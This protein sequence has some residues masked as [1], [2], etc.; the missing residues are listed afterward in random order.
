MQHKG[1]NP[2]IIALYQKVNDELSDEKMVPLMTE[3]NDYGPTYIYEGLSGYDFPDFY[4]WRHT[5][6][7]LKQAY[8]DWDVHY[9]VMLK[10]TQFEKE[11]GKKVLKKDSVSV[12]YE[13]GAGYI[14]QFQY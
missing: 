5:K 9:A 7:E 13:N 2:Q 6:E 4:E 11:H 12:Y 10:G 14:L 1:L 8:Y 3:E